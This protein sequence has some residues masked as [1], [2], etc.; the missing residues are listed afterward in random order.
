MGKEWHS[1]EST[2]PR[3]RITKRTVKAVEST[4]FYCFTN[5]L[6]AMVKKGKQNQTFDVL[7]IAF[8]AVRYR[9]V[10]TWLLNRK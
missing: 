8:W 2:G 5:L 9:W 3:A 4:Y 7:F 6:S 1:S 10:E